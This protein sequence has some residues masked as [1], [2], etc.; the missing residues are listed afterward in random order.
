[1][2]F[3]SPYIHTCLSIC[4]VGEVI[5]CFIPLYEADQL[6]HIILLQGWETRTASRQEKYLMR[7]YWSS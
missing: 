5:G 4:D 3:A 7:L 1:M 2:S 6:I